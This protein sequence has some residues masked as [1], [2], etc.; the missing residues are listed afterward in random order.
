MRRLLSMVLPVGVVA[1]AILAFAAPASAAGTYTHYVALGDSYS[2]GVGTGSYDSASGSCRRSP[3]AYPALWAAA[4]PGVSFS[5]VACSGATTA[6]VTSGQLSAVT[7]STDLVSIGV[8]G[9]DVG[10]VSV[11]SSCVLSSDSGCLSAVATATNKA[12]TVLPGSLA[13]LYAQI[14]SRAPGAHVVVIDYPRFYQLNG[15]C[16]TGMS[17]TKRSAINN[18]ADILDGV[19][20]KAAADAGFTFADVRGPFTNHGICS[21]S[22]WLNSL[23]WPVD[24]SYHP[25]SA[26]QSQGYYPT[27]A[28]AV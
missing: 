16:I 3:K 26:G 21:S 19:I 8:G 6:S 15:S 13:T 24:D 1:A 5:F 4:H 23:T 17:E 27:F 28:A 2:S 20:A 25:N 9:N 7:A 10:F 18:G 11:L 12:Q 14:R 22:W